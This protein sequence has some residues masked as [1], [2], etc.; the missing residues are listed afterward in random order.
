VPVI[1]KFALRAM[2]F[3][4]NP[5]QLLD[6]HGPGLLMFVL[7]MGLAAL[8][9]HWTWVFFAPALETAQEA[10]APS[11][12]QI[13]LQAAEQTVVSAHL[14]GEAKSGASGAA[15]AIST[16]GIKLKGVFAALG[17]LPGFAIVNTGAKTDLPVKVNDEFVPGVTLES[18]HPRHIIVRRAGVSERINLEGK[19]DTAL[20][21]GAPSNAAAT[22]GGNTYNVSRNELMATLQSGRGA[23]LGR[24]SPNPGGGMLIDDAPSGSISEKL[25]LRQGDVVRRVNGQPVSS[26]ADVN[27]LS[28]QFGPG[29]QIT[30]EVTRD[31]RP[32]QLSYVVQQ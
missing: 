17:N 21:P 26:Q 12:T 24:F 3:L 31:G 25:G 2:A 20:F 5:Q 29:A 32:L 14:F 18:V 27:R 28:Q 23:G 8:L 4:K 7:M 15:E 1:S 13:N 22:A 9:A 16:L 30:A 11:A 6:R 19:A 10:A